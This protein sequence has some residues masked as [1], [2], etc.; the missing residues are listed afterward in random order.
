MVAVTDVTVA[1][2][3]GKPNHWV[4]CRNDVASSNFNDGKTSQRWLVVPHGTPTLL[5]EHPVFVDPS[6]NPQPSSFLGLFR[7][8]YQPTE[9]LRSIWPHF[10]RSLQKWLVWVAQT[11]RKSQVVLFVRR[12]KW[13]ACTS[14]Y[15][16]L[17]DKHV[18]FSDQCCCRLCCMFCYSLR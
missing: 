14:T 16:S 17:Q 11:D 13:L 5:G 18:L 2:S 10:C 12:L 7:F 8:L 1:K 15:L 9:H 3:L 6:I 4:K